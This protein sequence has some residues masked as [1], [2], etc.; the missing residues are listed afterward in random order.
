MENTHNQSIFFKIKNYKIQKNNLIEGIYLSGEDSPYFKYFFAKED[1]NK[2]NLVMMYENIYRRNIFLSS[3]V[4][5]SY[6]I[7]KSILWKR[8]YFAYFF[9]HTR[10]ISVIIYIMSLNLLNKNFLANLKNAEL[11]GYY[12][13]H[14]TLID[15]EESIKVKY[16]KSKLLNEKMNI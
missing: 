9:Y 8:G 16:M 3:V 2:Q 15:V 5:M 14:K 6:N 10:M 7:V 1:E 11:L 13:K 4:F 12:K